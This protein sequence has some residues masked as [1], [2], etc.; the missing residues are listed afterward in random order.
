MKNRTVL[1]RPNLLLTVSLKRVLVC[2]RPRS[3]ARLQSEG[4]GRR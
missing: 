3:T 1:G 4:R 2:F